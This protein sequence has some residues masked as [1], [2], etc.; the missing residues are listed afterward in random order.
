MTLFRKATMTDEVEYLRAADIARITGVSIRTARRWIANEVIPST[1]L[2]GARLVAKADLERL[3]FSSP[4]P[5]EEVD[6][7]TEEYDCDSRK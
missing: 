5:T 6:G 4:D 2:G 1:R 3:L 7:R